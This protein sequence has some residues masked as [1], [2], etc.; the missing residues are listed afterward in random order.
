MDNSSI[1]SPGERPPK[2]DE[3]MGRARERFRGRQT[4]SLEIQLTEEEGNVK[5][6]EEDV[7]L[8]GGLIP[9]IKRLILWR[10]QW[11]LADNYIY[12][13]VTEGVRS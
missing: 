6:S 4:T 8:K 1:I 11:I 9:M 7:T 12:G 13:D 5:V 10:T 2:R 3:G